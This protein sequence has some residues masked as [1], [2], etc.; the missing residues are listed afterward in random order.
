VRDRSVGGLPL[1]LPELLLTVPMLCLMMGQQE[2]VH[3][4]VAAPMD[5]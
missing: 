5:R 3:S 2:Q 1:S 4:E